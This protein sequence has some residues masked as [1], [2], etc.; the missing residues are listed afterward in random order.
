MAGPKKVA[1][2]VSKK[3]SPIKVIDIETSNTDQ[4]IEEQYQKLTQREHILVRPDSYV[5]SLDLR[6]E[7][8]QVFDSNKKKNVEKTISFSPGLYKIYDEILVN[9]ADHGQRNSSC[10]RFDIDISKSEGSISV[11]NNGPGIPVVLHKEHNIYVP[12]LIFGHLLTGTNFNDKTQKT[13][14]GRNGYGAKLTNIFSTEFIIET[15][16]SDT[17][18]KFVQVFNDNMSVENKPKITTSKLSSYTKITFKPDLAKFGL[19]ELTDDIISLFIKRAYD[20]AGVCPGSTVFIN[21]EKVKFKSFKEYI[22]IF[23]LVPEEE[24]QVKTEFS[25]LIYHSQDRWQV[26]IL[27]AP[28][29]SFKQISYVNSICTYRGGKHVDLILEE[30]YAYVRKQIAKKDKKMV[31][32]DQTIKDNFVLF[33]NS[34]IVNP[35]FDTQTKENLTLKKANFGSAPEL[36][37][38]FFKSLN[39]VGLVEQIINSVQ[40]KD[41]TTLA[42]KAKKG[43]KTL[44][45]IIKLVDAPKA[46]T[47][48]SMQCSLFLPEGDSA[49]ALVMAGFSEIDR[50]YYGVFPLKGKLMNVREHSSTMVAKNEEI[51]NICR[52]MGL[53]PDFS[54]GGR[55]LGNTSIRDLRY[56]RIIIMT[57]QDTD[58]FHIKGLLLNFIHYFWPELLK[59]PGFV[60]S[61]QTQVVRATKN[62]SIKEFYNLVDFENWRKTATSGWFIKYYKGLGSSTKA[63]AKKYFKQI[64]D[65]TK[66]FVLEDSEHFDEKINEDFKKISALQSTKKCSTKKKKKNSLNDDEDE[67]DE[68]H[69]RNYVVTKKYNDPNTEAITLTFEKTRTD[70]RKGWLQDVIP[71]VLDYTMP[72]VSIPEFIHKEL[73]L[74]SYE[75]CERSICAIDG[76]KP[77]LRKIL[78][79]LYKQGIFNQKKELKV[80]QV[81]GLVSTIMAYHHGED[82][83]NKATI[84]M[85][86]KFCGAPNTPLLYPDGQFGSRMQN[87]ADAASP[88]YIYTYISALCQ[89]LIRKEDDPVLDYMLDDDGKKV[90]PVRYAAICPL[91]LMN[92]SSGIGSGFSTTIPQFNPK[93][94]IAIY[95]ALANGE[96]ADYDIIPWYTGFKGTVLKGNNEGQF[97]IYGKYQI[98]DSCSL[99]ITELPVGSSQSKSFDKYKEFLEKLRTENKI[100]SFTSKFDDANCEITVT[101]EEEDLDKLRSKKL[102]YAFFKLCT[103][104]K[105]TNMNMYNTQGVLTYYNNIKEIIDEYYQFRYNMYTKRKQYLTGQLTK[106]RDRLAWKVKFIDD[107][108][109]KVIKVNDMPKSEIIN[110]LSDHGY[111]MFV[112]SDDKDNNDDEDELEKVTKNK[113]T[114]NYDYLLTM[115]IYNLTRE[116]IVA[117]KA[118]LEEKKEELRIVMETTESQ[119][120]LIELDEFER[121]YDEWYANELEEMS[122]NTGT[123]KPRTK[124]N[125]VK[126][127][128]AILKE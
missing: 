122:Q 89:A 79:S 121:V 20:L 67:E 114:P 49:K 59:I 54:N 96:Q 53:T 107:C 127:K 48:D 73:K 60:T 19:E 45:D 118:K 10:N 24:G 8:L 91:V 106:E 74:F 3:T 109:A 11:K 16:D 44:T 31:V 105:T 76:L 4:T 25:D 83:L 65:L 46:G 68:E 82:S 103:S 108:I 75:D 70:D 12:T 23:E 62:S 93:D 39:D 100:N 58:G 7:K 81:S 6:V 80:A 21:G 14:G 40:R 2:K 71:G 92:G 104:V 125:V 26:G 85:A 102:V 97:L 43:T 47:K 33:L 110:Q 15:V 37:A 50:D 35:I 32:K 5:G 9:A 117:L 95:R 66:S 87:G 30:I 41:Q 77:S 13:T 78:K 119:Q 72:N 36:T 101:M 124:K 51:I 112:N 69:G 63:D 115:K 22:D 55:K 61:F 116:Y 1:K 27:F 84:G 56:G 113:K 111:P 126:K 38:K 18:K 86:Q 88:R 90:E 57:D 120:W 94:I 99:R 34:T 42:K 64:T 123:E 52:I 29:Q 98:I 128:K 28:N 17:Q